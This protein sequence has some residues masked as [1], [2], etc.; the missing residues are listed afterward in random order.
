MKKV[1]LILNIIFVILTFVGAFYVLG[2]NGN[3]NAGYAV[4]PMVFALIFIFL[5][6]K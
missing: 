5:Y 3:V 6:R 1:F 4:I 2:N